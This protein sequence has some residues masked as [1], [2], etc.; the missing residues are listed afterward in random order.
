MF[1][2]KRKFYAK[3]RTQFINAC[4]VTAIARARANGAA[5][6]DP[7]NRQIDVDRR[8]ALL[9]ARNLDAIGKGRGGA[10]RPA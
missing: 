3:Q 2:R 5:I 9:L 7:L 1:D 10:V 8:H 4:V 6:E